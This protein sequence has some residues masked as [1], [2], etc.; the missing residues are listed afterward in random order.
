M[1]T[2][3]RYITVFI[4]TLVLFL[5]AF[6][7]SGKLA[8]KKIDQI[9]EIQE[10]ISLDIL[11]TETRYALLGASSCDHIV[12]NQD[13]EEEL[14]G[15]LNDLA[16]RVKFMES[17]VSLTNPDL[18]QV[19][20]QYNLFQIK[21]YL[22]REELNKRCGEKIISILYFHEADCKDCK[23]ESVVLDELAYNFPEVRI[24]WLDKDLKTPAMETLVSIFNIKSAPA[25]I[26]N[27]KRYDGF[28]ELDTLIG[29]LPKDLKK[30]Y[31]ES[32]K[33]ETTTDDELNT[34]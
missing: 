4:I 25:L 29:L 21:D 23:K 32:Q 9:R 1:F 2:W 10:K 8:N 5:G 7:L 16:R 20:E 30:R 34:N 6:Y 11:S 19:K 14:N 22:L 18:I 26:M 3:K 17:Q 15:E 13:F 27:D 31:E 33:S 12:A 24:Y 28:Q